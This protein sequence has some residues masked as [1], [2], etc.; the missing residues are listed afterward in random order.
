MRADT[1]MGANRG[2]RQ[3]YEVEYIHHPDFTKVCDVVASL[4][5]YYSTV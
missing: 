4:K 1:L 3:A 2:L 5:M